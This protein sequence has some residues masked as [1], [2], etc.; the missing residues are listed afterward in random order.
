MYGKPIKSGVRTIAAIVSLAAALAVPVPGQAKE[1][2]TVTVALEGGYAPWNLTLPGGKLGGF[3]PELLAD[4]CARIKLQCNMVAQDWDGMIPGLQAGKFDVLM[5]AISITPER[6]K[7]LAFSRPYAATPATFAVTDT[8][9]IPKSDAA[10]P[11]V[12]LTGDAKADKPTVDTLRK[13]LKGKTI[14]IQSGTVYTKFINDSF[15][16]VATIRVYKTSPE[17]DLDLVA[18]RIDASF[19]DV[20]YYAANAGKKETAS[21]VLAG[22]KLGGPIWGPGEGLAFR[23]QDADLKAKFDT[24]IGAALADGTVKKLA[25]KWFK[26]D[27]TP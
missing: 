27:V 7:I 3:E 5:D 21:I 24:A 13:Q 17:R 15:K 1:W 23:K 4:V 6:E 22:P 8:K 14:G 26:T 9:V 19:D 16:D 12:K 2:K 18:G 10:A 25:D 11:V 20:T